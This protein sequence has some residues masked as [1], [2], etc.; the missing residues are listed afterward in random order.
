MSAETPPH[1]GRTT[2]TLRDLGMFILGVVLT[3]VAL[4]FRPEVVKL[5]VYDVECLY[6]HNPITGHWTQVTLWEA[7]PLKQP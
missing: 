6:T 1:V 5:K 3:L 2:V 7:C 4:S